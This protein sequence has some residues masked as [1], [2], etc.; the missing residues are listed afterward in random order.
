MD[1]PVMYAKTML[2]GIQEAHL[3]QR[4]NSLA[5]SSLPLKK[6]LDFFNRVAFQRTVFRVMSG[7]MAPEPEGE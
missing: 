6:E 4:G 2:K 7:A 5:A 1:Y 3:E